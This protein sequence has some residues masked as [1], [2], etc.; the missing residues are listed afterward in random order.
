MAF[1]SS[2]SRF[3]HK[4]IAW[5][6]LAFAGIFFELCALFFQHVMLLQPCVMCVYERVAMLG[7]VAA[8]LVGLLN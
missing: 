4:R 7:L 1:I 2:L 3:T 8:G 6:Q 5:A